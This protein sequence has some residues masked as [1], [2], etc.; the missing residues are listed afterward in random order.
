MKLQ[1][2][3][4]YSGGHYT[5]YIE[6]LLPELKT[7]LL[8]NQLSEVVITITKDHYE[9]FLHTELTKK[10]E[11]EKLNLRFDASLEDVGPANTWQN[12]LHLYKAYQKA[13]KRERADV[14]LRV[15]ADYDIAFDALLK[16]VPKFKKNWRCK[17]IG[18][19][20]YGFPRDG[21]LNWKEQIKQFGFEFCWK[22]STWDTLF[23]VNPVVYESA[24]RQRILASKTLKLLPDP[25]LHNLKL[26][27]TQSRLTL[28]VPVDGIYIGFVG[29]MDARKAIPELIEAF[30]A[31]NSGENC[32]L[33]LMGQMNQ[34]YFELIEK[35]YQ[36]LIDHGKVIIVNRHL[37]T[38]EVQ[39]GYAAIDIHALLQYRRMNLSANL[40]KAVVARRMIIADECG[41][42]GMMLKRFNLGEICNVNDSESI[43][44]AIN[45]AKKNLEHF[46]LNSKALKLS[47]FHHPD[48][49]SKTLMN[50]ILQHSQFVGDQSL[51]TWEWVCAE[52]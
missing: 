16:Y 36:D 26:N 35:N 14:I 8:N 3:E 25:V 6:S 20:H 21:K 4:A 19:F 41:Y 18:I 38:K 46:E 42:T 10:N 9:R 48:N 31:S 24:S 15:T 5:N 11:E 22:Y 47:E 44:V 49:F 13:I 30:K 43:K 7:A 2:L 1:I 29:M 52:V 12:K 28:G 33:L 45:N 50:A 37:S 39:L 51:K 27:V 32:R 40:L 17:S 23:F 34:L